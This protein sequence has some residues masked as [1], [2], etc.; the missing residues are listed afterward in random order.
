MPRKRTTAPPHGLPV[1][2]AELPT[3]PQVYT[4]P[5][6]ARRWKCSRHTVTAAINAN[7]LQAFKVGERQFRIRHDEVVRY[8]TEHMGRKA[9]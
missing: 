7:R 3:E 8:E 5:E 9:S 6:L 1:L 4:V 2:P